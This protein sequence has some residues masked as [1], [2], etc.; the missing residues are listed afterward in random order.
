MVR[1]MS[2][3]MGIGLAALTACTF[4]ASGAG[5]AGSSSGT[6]DAASTGPRPETSS[7]DTTGPEPSGG[8]ETTAASSTTTLEP[9]TG[10][11][12][13]SSGGGEP[14]CDVSPPWWD[15]T[16]TRRRLVTVNAASV[17]EALTSVPIRLRLDAARIDYAAVQDGGADLR[18]VDER[19][20]ELSYEVEQ[21]DESGDSEVWLR[22][23]LV[24][25]GGMPTVWMYYGNAA[26]PAGSDPAGVWD[27]DFVS[28]H[29]LADLRDAT[30]GGHDGFGSNLPAD[31]EGRIGRGRAF[32]GS[33]DQIE[34]PQ[35]ADFDLE[36]AL[37]VEAW[38]RVASFTV[39]WQAIVTKGDDTW[40]LHRQLNTPF[41]G[42][43][44]DTA[45]TNDNLSG[46]TPIDDGDWHH[47][48]IV[49]GD[50]TKQIYVDGQLDVS[51]LYFGPLFV[52]DA[53]VVLGSNADVTG[54][55]FHGALD[56]VRISRVARSTA[57]IALQA[58]ATADASIV[59][60]GDEETCP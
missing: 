11:S 57:W 20:T 2:T 27:D 23:P 43:G 54:R 9:V 18:F 48:A 38:A 49:Y 45:L 19:S 31:V 46:T 17:T 7:V 50:D 39:D 3:R 34:L 37:T 59:S 32:D 35:E 51:E 15:L 30:A 14:T 28:V 53:P 25:A 4:D 21:W 60:V 26:A 13:S 12:D 40:R 6:S 24:P 42:F 33:N 8:G 55:F 5:T 1:R 47:V 16:F 36:D 44:S 41:V 52:T 56:E 58:R 10:S 29:H 22:L